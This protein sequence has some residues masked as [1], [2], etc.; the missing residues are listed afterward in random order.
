MSDYFQVAKSIRQ[1]FDN[2][3]LH[4]EISF[5]NWM[6][7][8]HLIGQRF[9]TNLHKCQDMEYLYYLIHY[10]RTHF[11]RIINLSISGLE[12]I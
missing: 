7:H 12:L 2:I 6:I 5:D 4:A 1:N 11:N 10:T 3:E 9:Q 8:R